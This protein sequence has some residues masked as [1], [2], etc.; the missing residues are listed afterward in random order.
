M[1]NLIAEMVGR[2][3]LVDVL[4]T[5]T[6][7]PFV[8]ALP[9]E[10]GIQRLPSSHLLWG[11]PTLACYLRRRRPG[12]VLTESPRVNVLAL[13]A[14][15]LARTGTPVVASIHNTYSKT[16]AAQL[17]RKRAAVLRRLRRYLPRNDAVIAVSRGVA[18]DLRGL[19]DLPSERLHV[20]ANPV[21]GP[22]LLEQAAADPGHPW[23]ADGGPPVLLAAGRLHPQKD[24][25]TLLRAFARVR[26]ERPCRLLVL[27]E[28]EGR[29]AL[30][31]L[32]LALRVRDYVDLPGF[33]DNPYA[34][35]A[36]AA[37]FVLSSAWE[38]FGNVLVEALAVGTPAVATDCP[39]GP[40]E[41][42]QD[43]RVGPL[44]PVG[45]DAALAAAILEALGR[46]V[47]RDRLRQ[48]TRPYQTAT[49]TSRYLEVLGL[50]GRA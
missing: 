5:K 21:I 47:D 32:A 6:G 50:S 13:R 12:A 49:V 9:A 35:M 36:R 37:V 3:L 15:T 10:V 14:R 25:A 23:L 48:A 43:G 17:P 19:V 20:I 42:L 28:G 26:G 34:Y 39:H 31:S 29:G 44:V 33:V 24:F 38:G 18:E 16:L 8:A 27:G 2:G 46:P 7:G 45:D 11:V 1:V 41:I 22:D 30:E 40:R 4:L